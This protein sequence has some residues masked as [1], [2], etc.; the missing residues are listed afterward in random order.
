MKFF[1]ITR[2]ENGACATQYETSKIND[3]V[4]KLIRDGYVEDMVALRGT[5][6]TAHTP[7]KSFKVIHGVTAHIEVTS[8]KVE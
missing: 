2:N 8:V 3:A 4:A 7:E 1:L 6:Y 5:S